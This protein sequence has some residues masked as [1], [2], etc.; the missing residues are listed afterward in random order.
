MRLQLSHRKA[1]SA[2]R[3]TYSQLAKLKQQL[4]QQRVNSF[5]LLMSSTFKRQALTWSKTSATNW[6]TDEQSDLL[7]AK[8]GSL[9]EL[10]M[11][12]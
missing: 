12:I 8:P 9:I 1:S 11:T 6:R 2:R 10:C 4:K 3:G 5:F 7:L